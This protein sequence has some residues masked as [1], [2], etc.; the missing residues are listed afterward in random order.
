VAQARE[1]LLGKLE[2]LSSNPI[3]MGERGRVPAIKSVGTRWPPRSGP[4]GR[5]APSP[6]YL[7]DLQLRVGLLAT[8]QLHGK[9]GLRQQHGVPVLAAIRVGQFGTRP[10]D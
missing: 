8:Q 6:P 1:R 4:N 3:L 5:P 7:L 10:G 2:A 9:A